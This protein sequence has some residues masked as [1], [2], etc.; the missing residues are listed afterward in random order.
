[1]TIEELAVEFQ[2]IFDPHPEV[3]GVSKLTGEIVQSKNGKHEAR[4]FLIRKPL[5]QEVWQ[6]HLLG[7]QSIGV[8]PIRPDNTVKWGA[9][10]I[11]IYEDK[12][13][14][15][16]LLSKISQHQFPFVVCRSKSGGAHLFLFFSEPIPA[17]EVI[18][19][20]QSFSGFFGQGVS[21]IFPKQPSIGTRKDDSEFGNW[22]NMPYDGPDSLR[23]A[24]TQQQA[25]DPMDFI[26][27]VHSLRLTREQFNKLDIPVI[28]DEPFPEGPPCLNYIFLEKLQDGAMRNIT[29]CN[30]AVYLKKIKPDD[31]QHDL[32]KYNKLF[33]EPLPD[34]EV[35][36][37]IKSYQKK[38]YRYQCSKEPLCRF[39]DA[40]RCASRQYGIGGNSFQPN[41]RSLVLIKTTPPLWYLTIDGKE[42][43]L[44]TEQFDIHSLFTRKVMETLLIKYPPMKQED[45]LDIQNR[46]LKNCTVIDIPPEMSPKG[47]LIAHL[48]EF[49]NLAQDEQDAVFKGLPWK[50]PLGYLIF[51]MQDFTEYLDRSRFKA[52]NHNEILSTLK[53]GIDAVPHEVRKE[54]RGAR[55][56]KVSADKLLNT[57]HPQ[58]PNIEQNEP[59]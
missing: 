6:N 41:N 25:L 38:E 48:S 44:T 13:T 4:S 43:Q 30:V 3:Y 19:K 56:W 15:Q 27:Q 53:R 17:Q 32:P 42:I 11:D 1:M 22:L 49:A 46:L 12:T 34:R 52:L 28:K 2:N 10:D 57:S 54:G 39:C 47:Q 58:L 51:R 18:E 24:Y 33:P 9:L 16:Q 59:F 45:W 36:A 7:K 29:L 23:F 50:H 5:T 40:K 55:C 20:L 26:K 37:I 8:V 21:E 14:T 31:W 35:E